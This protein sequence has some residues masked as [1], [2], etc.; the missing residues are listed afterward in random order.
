MQNIKFLIGVNKMKRKVLL[1][2]ATGNFGSQ[3]A[4]RFVTNESV[5]LRV[6]VRSPE[7]V[8]DL[9]AKGIQVVR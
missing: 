5:D 6:L 3:L 8:A 2:G 4:L 9:K 1:T 7:K